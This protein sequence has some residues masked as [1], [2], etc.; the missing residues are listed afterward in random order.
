MMQDSDEKAALIVCIKRMYH[1]RVRLNL[2][3]VVWTDACEALLRAHF[4]DSPD[5]E[6]RAVASRSP[7]VTP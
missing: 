6:V 4:N 1:L 3:G 7:F 2:P 5:P